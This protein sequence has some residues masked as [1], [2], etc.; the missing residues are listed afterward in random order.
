MGVDWPELAT[1]QLDWHWN[2]QLR[3]RLVGLSD[4]EYH[5]EPVADCWRICPA[6][7]STTVPLWG[8]GPF[9]MEQ[10]DGDP[11][12]AP[13]TTIAWRIAHIIVEVFG[14]RVHSHFGGPPVT[15]E[16]FAFAGTADE[17][18]AQLDAAHTAWS[19]GARSLGAEGM[20]RPCGP[21]EGP[22]A[23]MPLAGL[24]LHINRE[25]IHHGA[26][27]ALLRD[28]YRHQLAGRPEGA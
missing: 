7:T 10:A 6:D 13:A 28:L 27:I 3:P 15:L 11:D 26:E 4:H 21:S 9:R 17:A 14:E 18:L 5:W 24:V 22:F 16:T 1:D 8:T 23:E 2:Y 12:P 25:V 20:A 19:D